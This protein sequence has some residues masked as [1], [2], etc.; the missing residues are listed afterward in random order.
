[1][2]RKEAKVGMAPGEAEN[3]GESVRGR[4]QDPE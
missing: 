3:P 4:K 2:V 1:M